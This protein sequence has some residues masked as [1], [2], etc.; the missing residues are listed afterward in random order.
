MAIKVPRGLVRLSQW[1]MM[2]KEY[3]GYTR[4]F[5]ATRLENGLEWNKVRTV[6]KKSPSGISR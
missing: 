6:K 1:L 5:P 3:F 4:Q 2:A